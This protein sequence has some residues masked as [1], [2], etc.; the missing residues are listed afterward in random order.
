MKLQTQFLGRQLAFFP[1]LRRA[2]ICG[3]QSTATRESLGTVSLS[4]SNRLPANTAPMSVNPVTFPPGRGRLS[5]SPAATGSTPLKKTMGIVLVA[6]LATRASLIPGR[7]QYVNF[8]TEQLI[9]E[10][11][12]PV[13]LVISES[14]LERLC[15]CPQHSRDHEVCAV[16]SLARRL[17]WDGF[18]AIQSYVPLPAAARQL[19]TTQP[20]AW[21]SA[22][23]KKSFVLTVFISRLSPHGSCLSNNFIRPY[24][25]I[26]RNRQPN[27]FGGFSLITNSIFVG[28]STGR[29]AGL[30]PFKILST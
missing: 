20:R 26:R 17:K 2:W 3:S 29:S 10:A 7:D 1:L 23:T 15:S 19:S 22:P 8:E 21:Q 16:L 28:C 30:V 5:T 12:E 9:S 13:E 6:F 4:S 18:R 27:L 25:Y 14:I 11:G 24:Q